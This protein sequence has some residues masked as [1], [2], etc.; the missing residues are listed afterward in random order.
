MLTLGQHVVSIEDTACWELFKRE[1][2][3]SIHHQVKL[4][5]A[6]EDDYELISNLF[7]IL[8]VHIKEL[9]AFFSDLTT[10]AIS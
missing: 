6:L 3:T 7:L 5:L 8:F 2:R 4:N 9:A 1:L 10:T